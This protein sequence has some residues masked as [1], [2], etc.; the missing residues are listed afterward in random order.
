M[1]VPKLY[2][3]TRPQRPAPESPTEPRFFARRG[4][5]SHDT[6][7]GNTDSDAKVPTLRPALAQPEPRLSS[8]YKRK[9]ALF[10][11]KD[12]EVA[13]AKL[14]P[15]RI[16]QDKEQLYE[17][18]LALKMENNGLRNEN[19]RLRTRL[20]QLEKDIARKD[21][22][23]EE[24]RGL[25]E[26]RQ[27]SSVLAHSHLVAG[28]KQANRD[29]RAELAS[30]ETEFEKLKRLSKITKLAE[31][32]TELKVYIEECQRLKDCLM[33][34]QPI[35][36][37][38]SVLQSQLF[39]VKQETERLKRHNQELE[40]MVKTQDEAEEKLAI[41]NGEIEELQQQI[42]DL[43]TRKRNALMEYAE[44][45]EKLYKDRTQEQNEAKQLK[46]LLNE[47][48]KTIQENAEKI[49]NL[50]L[51]IDEE[52]AKNQ[53]LS[54]QITNFQSE[55]IEKGDLVRFII[56]KTIK[57]KLEHK[58]LTAFEVL[59]NPSENSVKQVKS[60]F[61]SHGVKLKAWQ[62]EILSTRSGLS[63]P[64]L[65]EEIDRVEVKSARK[66]KQVA[67]VPGPVKRP[68]LTIT[69]FDSVT[70]SGLIRQKSSK[71]SH[72]SPIKSSSSSRKSSISDHDAFNTLTASKPPE[73]VPSLKQEKDLFRTDVDMS[74]SS[75]KHSEIDGKVTPFEVDPPE[76]ESEGGKTPPVEE[77]KAYLEEPEVAAAQVSSNEDLNERVDDSLLNPKEESKE[78]RSYTDLEEYRESMGRTEEIFG[79]EVENA[80]NP[81]LGSPLGVIEENAGYEAVFEEEK[82]YATERIPGMTGTDRELEEVRDTVGALHE[83]VPVTSAEAR[84]TAVPEVE[85]APPVE[86]KS[87]PE[88]SERVEEHEPTPEVE[89][90]VPASTEAVEE[91][92]PVSPLVEA[93]VPEPTE[94]VDMPTK[95]VSED[96]DP[97]SAEVV[98]EVPAATEVD[99]PAKQ[100]DEEAVP[101][102]T[103]QVEEPTLPRTIYEDAVPASTEVVDMPAKQVEEE[104]VPAPI[105]IVEERRPVT[106]LHEDKPP[107]SSEIV[108]EHVPEDAI[109]PPTDILPEPRV[110]TTEQHT[111]APMTSEEAPPAPTTQEVEAPA[112]VEQAHEPEVSATPPPA[113]E[114]SLWGSS[115]E[116]A[117]KLET[118]PI[119]DQ[120]SP[121][122][123]RALK[124]LRF[125]LLSHGLSKAQFTGAFLA[126]H[127][128]TAQ[129]NPT[130]FETV[131]VTAPFNVTEEL[132][133][134]T[135]R[136]TSRCAT[137]GEAAELLSDDLPH[138]EVLS[139]TQEDIRNQQLWQLFTHT[140]D[141]HATGELTSDFLSLSSFELLVLK[142]GY[143]LDVS[144]RH[145]IEYLSYL[146]THQ[147]DLI[148]Y[149]QLRHAFTTT[150]A[151]LAA[152]AQAIAWNFSGTQQEALAKECALLL[153]NRLI[154]LNV[155]L[156]TAFQAKLKE[157]MSLEELESGLKTLGLEEACG[158][159]SAA[160]V[161][162]TGSISVSTLEAFLLHFGAHPLADKAE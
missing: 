145:Y 82:V 115:T 65:V 46:A 64:S 88:S 152:S 128:P 61:K 24:L 107:E 94:V 114:N 153:S 130:D 113:D 71:K 31:M 110:E 108:E 105:E 125:S 100:A 68:E 151:E 11:A 86:E 143:R 84:E 150:Q 27:F 93:T 133:A 121:Q 97:V 8:L 78:E 155:S 103:D 104:S 158:K 95:T 102:P 129:L 26:E 44:E 6:P 16:R 136:V 29:L 112:A 117:P 42:R 137:W 111:P 96:A 81:E 156:R 59:Q 57:R 80:S 124:H 53:K 98:G 140:P 122:V 35:G 99:M 60:A 132:E 91:H 34:G 63:I 12:R 154:E 20:N 118:R 147:L 3:T 30:R 40:S 62:L 52:K 116:A 123:E 7:R 119:A 83:D 109:P 38:D 48:E 28:L 76:N 149:R 32:E 159:Q 73:R 126:A 89:A 146:E 90:I 10:E 22:F 5:K 39:E 75:G 2:E 77:V 9:P 160:L 41:A 161:G 141:F 54:T 33:E 47:K 66:I 142:H 36:S 135:H 138:W 106:P 72:K 13:A 45:M 144:L 134:L 79:A 162:E 17:D 55:A 56:L 21:D 14:R 4:L 139:K 49:Q 148:P 69:T 18:S 70:I 92:R 19:L 51:E 15:S 37:Q 25:S 127:P 131:L 74:L 85:K 43:E 87:V 1:S 50:E 23:L 101:A 157:E 58:G 120:P 67:A